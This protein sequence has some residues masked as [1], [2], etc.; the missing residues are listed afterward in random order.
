MQDTLLGWV[1]GEYVHGAFMDSVTN[2]LGEDESVAGIARVESGPALVAARNQLARV[3]MSTPATW[4]FMVDTDMVFDA[5]VIA[6]LKQYASPQVIAGAL[7]FGWF[8][9]QRIAKPTL[10]G[11]GMQQIFDW[12]DNEVVSVEATGA[13]ALLIHR[14]VFET[15]PEPWFTQDPHGMWGEDQ[16]FCQNVRAAGNGIVVDTSTQVLHA[17]TLYVGRGDYS[18]DALRQAFKSEQSGT[19]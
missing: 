10:Y 18:A 17:K 2:L 6:R 1:R 19:M 8:P 4:L 5:D 12:D 13:A 9:E 15:T 3:F 11:P 7:C 16:G 14:H